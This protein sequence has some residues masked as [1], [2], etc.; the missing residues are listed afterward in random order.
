MLPDASSLKQKHRK[1]IRVALGAVLVL[2]LYAAAQLGL[3]I[4]SDLS[5]VYEPA[6][7]GYYRVIEV[8]DGDTFTVSMGG[9]E[10]QVRLVGVD[11]PETQHPA[12]PVQCYGP[13]ASDYT[14]SLIE[15]AAVKLKADTQQSNR[16]RYDRLLRYVYL[17]DGR[18]LNELLVRNGYAF[19]TDF[20]TENKRKLKQL[21][22]QARSEK[23]GLWGECNVSESGGYLQTGSL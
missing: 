12:K 7:P 1:I 17:E 8:A 9:T 20:N 19:A 22:A 13:E 4:T 11:T 14:T 3:N 15:G 5:R 16:D 23:Q 18:E 10:E 21:Q 6:P 2:V